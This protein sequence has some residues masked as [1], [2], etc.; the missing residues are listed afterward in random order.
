MIPN[1]CYDNKTKEDCPDRHE[2]CATTC[3]K[4][5]EYESKRKQHYEDRQ[6]ALFESY[7]DVERVRALSRK[8]KR[9]H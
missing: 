9:N 3:K 8:L 6:K 2:C 5:K 4:W 1:P 7:C